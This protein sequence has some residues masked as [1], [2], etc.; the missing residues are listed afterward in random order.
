M[1][2]FNKV[3]GSL[4]AI[5]L[6]LSIGSAQAAMVNFT[7]TGTVVFADAGNLFGLN[8][9]D[10]VSVVGSFDDSVLTLGTGTV[11]FDAFNT[12]NTFNVTT[13]DFSFT[14]MNDIDY[15]IGGRP[16]LNLISGSLDNFDFLANIG[17]FGFFDSQ[18]GFFDGDDDNFGAISGT[19]DSFEMTVIPVPAAVW[20][21][22]SGLLGLVGIARRKARA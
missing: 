15:A 13:G 17:A 7:L 20:L 21:L 16:F 6:A 22:G 1:R 4:A 2:N 11:L 18:V 14:E 12:G 8:G 9:G 10:A 5:T 19:W 3:T